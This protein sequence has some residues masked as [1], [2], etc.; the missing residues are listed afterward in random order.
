VTSQPTTAENAYRAMQAEAGAWALKQY[1]EKLSNRIP[2]G[3]PTEDYED[4]IGIIL[5]LRE[6]AKEK[7]RLAVDYRR[8][9]LPD[10]TS[11]TPAYDA[12]TKL[13]GP[14]PTP[15]L[16][17]AIAHRDAEVLRTAADKLDA[18]PP[19][20]EALKG[21]YWYRDGIH[22]AADLCRDWADHADNMD[23]FT[24]PI[25]YDLMTELRHLR[26][27]KETVTAE[28]A[29]TRAEARNPQEILLAD[30]IAKRLDV[31]LTTPQPKENEKP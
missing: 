21:P 23:G 9:N 22:T 4:T 28:L 16:L 30:V 5:D 20:G 12:L 6:E 3:S 13:Y 7:K 27:F 17:T 2:D 18:L 8:A 11:Q 25:K 14:D 1:A 10:K 29:R 24:G 15:E 31:D 19:G 26:E